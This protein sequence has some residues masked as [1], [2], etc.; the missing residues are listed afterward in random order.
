MARG[1]TQL[2][3]NGILL[4]N[5]LTKTF[6]QEAVYDDSGTDLLYFRYTIAVR[7]YHSS[8]SVY[9]D[10]RVGVKWDPDYIADPE[11]GDPSNYQNPTTA[12]DG[13]AGTDYTKVRQK[14]L[15]PR[16]YF[17]FRTGV[18]TD[19]ATGLPTGTTLLE[20]RPIGIRDSNPEGVDVNNGPKPRNV[21]LSHIVGDEVLCIEFEIELCMVQC[22]SAGRVPDN[23]SGIVSN[24][25]SM[26]DTVDRNF[27]TTRTITGQLVTIN[28]N[29]N[30]HAMRKWVV[31]RLQPGFR[32]ESMSFVAAKDGLKLDYTI[33]D[34]EVAFAAPDPATDWN[35]QYRLTKSDA[36][37]VDVEIGVYL[38][39]PSDVNKRALTRIAIAVLEAR[40]FDLRQRRP[41]GIRDPHSVF[42][43]ELDL[44]DEQNG[45]VNSIRLTAVAQH[46]VPD[47]NKLLGILDENFGTPIDPREL[48]AVTESGTYDPTLSMGAKP[49]DPVHVHGPI[50]VTSAWHAYLQ[51]PCDENHSTTDAEVTDGEHGDDDRKD[52]TLDAYVADVDLPDWDDY[53][54]EANKVGVYTHWKMLSTY[55]K[56]A[57]RKALG[58][59]GRASTYAPGSDQ[60]TMAV[61][62][63]GL[64]TWKR[65][66]QIEAER[67]GG[68]SPVFP[69][70]KRTLQ[71]G[72]GTQELLHFSV[73][74]S[75]PRRSI[76][77]QLIH[78]A[79]ADY[80]YALTVSPGRYDRLP[81]GINPWEKEA[82]NKH[83][84]DYGLLTGDGLI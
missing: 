40:V 73:R 54:S 39:G 65:K 10:Q 60:P 30:P 21:E 16:G 84:T 26:S 9:E 46:N 51:Q 8:Q 77:G 11:S 5:V 52:Y 69:E 82:V 64:P 33:V 1:E 35:T 70:P 2:E 7:G 6:R 25:W 17:R 67:V 22:D 31:P 37:L 83:L 18:G 61:V 41:P 48:A 45:D 78:T 43:R 32:R 12:G 13:S 19:P 42:L 47:E 29:L 14:L 20:C 53:T 24:R 57:R 62:S 72:R 81:I 58:I 49:N 75:T 66:V 79:I 4:R 71:F 36:K 50:P 63:V 44:L 68:T 74:P 56:N 23:D 15:H 28:G 3:Y 34:K 76:D 27:Y 80:E 59:A 38:E 55:H